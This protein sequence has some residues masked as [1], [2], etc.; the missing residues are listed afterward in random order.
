MRHALII[1]LIFLIVALIV[2]LAPQ[3]AAGGD[4]D[5]GRAAYMDHCATCHGTDGRGGGPLAPVLV[6]APPDLTMLAA[7]EGGVF[8]LARALRRVDGT[9]EVLAHGGPMPVFGLILNGPSAAVLAPDGSE[10]VT[11]EGLADIM[12]WI[13]E[14]QR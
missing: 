6:V 8:P 12:A 10:I 2:M 4:A 3:G 13:E 14:Q 11:S 9:D 1:I 5:R 7:N